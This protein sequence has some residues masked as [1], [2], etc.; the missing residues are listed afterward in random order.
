[1]NQGNTWYDYLNELKRFLCDVAKSRWARYLFYPLGVFVAIMYMTSQAG[2]HPYSFFSMICDFVGCIAVITLCT[3]AVLACIF[4]ADYPYDRLRRRNKERD[5]ERIIAAFR[6]EYDKETELRIQRDNELVR[7]QVIVECQKQQKAQLDEIRQKQKDELEIL[8]GEIKLKKQELESCK[9]RYEQNY[10][11]LENVHKKSEEKITELTQ[12]IVVKKR[13]IEE[14]EAQFKKL[15]DSYNHRIE[16]LKIIQAEE[17][18]LFKQRTVAELRDDKFDLYNKVMESLE[19]SREEFLRE[20]SERV[21]NVTTYAVME[22][23]QFGFSP[24]SY[25]FIQHKVCTF[26]ET[27]GKF[28]RTELSPIVNPF[29]NDDARKRGRK[30]KANIVDIILTTQDIAHYTRNIAFYLDFRLEDVA[31]FTAYLFKDWYSDGD[32]LSIAK[33]AAKSP[34]SG[35][36]KI[37]ENLE[38][39]IAEQGWREENS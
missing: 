28:D 12:D 9:K 30:K 34:D 22:L 8:Q 5:N 2:A 16:E 24:E 11:N 18:D 36:I 17:M 19:K 3:M 26:A 35:F 10:Q 20:N 27:G 32:F 21:K 7:R 38:E 13:N 4:T 33:A 37:H 23:A 31:R 1:M 14:L 29:K 6:K 15:Q 39:Y 25:A